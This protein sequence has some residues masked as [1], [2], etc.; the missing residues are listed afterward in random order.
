MVRPRRLVLAVT[1]ALPVLAVL[2][3][4][5]ALAAEP[6]WISGTVTREG[7]PYN[8]AEVLVLVEGTDQ[9]VS[10]LTD[11]AGAFGVEV[12]AAE[13]DVVSVQAVGA[14][15][16]SG[17]DEHGCLHSETPVGRAS[18]VLDVLP[19]PAV[20]VVL[21]TL[22]EDSICGTSGTPGPQLTLPPTDV[23]A[24]TP[25]RD[26]AGIPAL[27]PVLAILL[28]GLAAP[29]VLAGRSA[30]HAPRRGSAAARAARRG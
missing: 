28:A 26:P 23:T 7:G 17:P 4:A 25:A 29:R 15:S 16:R 3:P 8:A 27:V 12:E 19:P 30:A 2:L 18:L 20:E 5:A 6:V 24:G 22:M 14:T 11:E 13:G 9:V 1:L 21:D 10:V